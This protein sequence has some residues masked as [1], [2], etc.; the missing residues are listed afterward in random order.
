MKGILKEILKELKEIKALLK[1]TDRASDEMIVI[2]LNPD[3]ENLLELE[4]NLILNQDKVQMYW[5]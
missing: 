3:S 4:K 5:C 1:E 2:G